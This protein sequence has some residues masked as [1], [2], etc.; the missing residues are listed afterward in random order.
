VTYAEICVSLSV[1]FSSASVLSSVRNQ[2]PSWLGGG[3]TSS[4]AN[5]EDPAAAPSAETPAVA[6]TSSSSIRPPSSGG[7]K[8]HI[9]PDKDSDASSATGGADSEKEVCAVC[10]MNFFVSCRLKEAFE[11]GVGG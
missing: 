8:G 10:T 1:L 3:K 11:W 4:S 7:D 2:L 6:E 5:K 9:T